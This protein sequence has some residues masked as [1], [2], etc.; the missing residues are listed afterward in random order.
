[1]AKAYKR[2]AKVKKGKMTKEGTIM[3][4]RMMRRKR[5]GRKMRKYGIT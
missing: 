1:M 5:I 2:K 4:G 3:L